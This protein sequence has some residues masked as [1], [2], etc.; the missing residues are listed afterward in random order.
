MVDMALSSTVNAS[1]LKNSNSSIPMLPITFQLEINVSRWLIRVSVGMGVAIIR[2]VDKV[3]I[4]ISVSIKDESTIST[5]AN[6]GMMD[7]NV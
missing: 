7:S 6:T 5:S 4:R 2:N 1:E 3:S